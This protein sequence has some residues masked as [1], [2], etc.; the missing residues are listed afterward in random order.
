MVDSFD[1]NVAKEYG[2]YCAIL[3]E[4]EKTR[5]STEAINQ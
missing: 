3:L 1:V 4:T 2:I 5:N